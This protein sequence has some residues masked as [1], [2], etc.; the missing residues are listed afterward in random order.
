MNITTDIERITPEIAKA[1]LMGNIDNRSVKTNLIDQYAGDMK[2][3]RW[4][5]T[6]QPIIFSD[7]GLLNDGQHRLLALIKSEATVTM[8]VT[9]G[10]PRESRSAID[11]GK[12]RGAGDVLQMF[13]IPNG[14]NIAALAASV[15][16]YERAGRKG[17]GSPNRVSKADII[18]RSRSDERLVYC[19]RLAQRFRDLVGRKQP[20]FARY[21]IPDGMKSDMFF[22]SF[23]DGAGLEHGHPVLTLRNWFLRNGRKN[24]DLAAI[25]AILRAWCAFRDGRSLAALKLLGEYPTP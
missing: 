25:E 24:T 4:Q 16:A 11:I 5:M 3:G 8:M 15:I 23:A 13:H 1:M 17:R 19:D 9:R 18:A 2:A 14:N 7:D 10:V 21:V 6:G 12:S 22:D 20:A